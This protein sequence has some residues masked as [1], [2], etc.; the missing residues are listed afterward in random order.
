MPDQS[1]RFHGLAG[2]WKSIASFGV[3]GVL[4]ALTV[5]L[6]IWILPEEREAAR[7]EIKAERAA[8]RLD[9]EKSREHGTQAAREIGESVRELSNTIIE[10]Q[11]KTHRNQERLIELQMKNAKVTDTDGN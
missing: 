9:A 5:Y 6:V 4:S 2:L 7:E 1:E 8:A 3:I 10:V 11:S